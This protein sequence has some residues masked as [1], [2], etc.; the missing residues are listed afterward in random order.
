[1][2]I[3]D[4]G[5]FL[6]GKCWWWWIVIVCIR[7]LS[8]A[9]VHQAAVPYQPGEAVYR[10]YQHRHWLKLPSLGRVYTPGRPPSKNIMRTTQYYCEWW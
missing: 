8:Q 3:P 10:N 4:K 6:A 9:A 7:A 1:M 5:G 2:R